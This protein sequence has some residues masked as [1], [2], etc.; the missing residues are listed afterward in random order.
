M[1]P[2]RVLMV[3]DSADD[4][5]LIELELRRGGYQA[6]VRRVESEGEL[7]EALAERWDVVVSD[8]VLPL[9]DGLGALRIVHHVDPDLPVVLVSGTIGEDRAVEALKAGAGDFVTKQNLSRLVTAIE[10]E[11][12]DAE[13]RRER[14]HTLAKLEAAVAARDQF[15]SIASHELKTPL[16]ALQLQLQSLERALCLG[17]ADGPRVVQKL[18]T[19]TRSSER[20]GELVNRLLDVSRIGEGPLDLVREEVDLVALA[21]EV[22]G[23]FREAQRESGALGQVSA[24]GPVRGRWDR[25][26]LDTILTNL[27][28]NALKYGLGK[29]VEVR[30]SSGGGRV[31]VAVE[32]H[33]IGIDPADHARIFQRYER[34]ASERHYGGFGVGLWVARLVAEAHDGR[35]DVQSVPG[36]GATFT[37]ELP[38][39]A[40]SAP[41]DA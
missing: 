26:R 38:L 40:R 11:M 24:A 34:A 41:R 19:V 1:K 37:L 14:R 12:R 29:P 35:I 6:E 22:V 4:A 27:L 5:L 18:K 28:S 23:R 30:V 31:R 16:T 32:D 9:L 21:E 2:L 20:L 25:A 33:G 36:E 17:E 13:V 3:E 39:E 15:L 8:Y 7:R 10:R